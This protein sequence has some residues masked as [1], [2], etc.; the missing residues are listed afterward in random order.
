MGMPSV[1]GIAGLASEVAGRA[2]DSYR[3][4]LDAQLQRRRID[5]LRGSVLAHASLAAVGMAV[6]VV[7]LQVRVHAVQRALD[8]AIAAGDLERAEV[9]RGQQVAMLDEPLA[10]ARLLTAL[11]DYLP[12]VLA[13]QQGRAGRTI[14]GDVA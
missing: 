5:S 3:A 14:K 4:R 11:A 1:A 8:D 2:V 9:L 13:E 6:D 7:A 10:G 12:A